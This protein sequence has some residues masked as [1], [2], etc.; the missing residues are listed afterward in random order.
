MGRFIEA[1]SLF[2]TQIIGV[3]FSWDNVHQAWARISLDGSVIW[4]GDTYG[5]WV[6]EDGAT[7]ACAV[8]ISGVSSGPHT[9]RVENTGQAG[10]DGGHT[11]AVLWLYYTLK[12]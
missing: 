9:I 10:A 5:H 11:V 2:N 12:R 4:E 8:E 1:T 7:M 3:Q 6:S